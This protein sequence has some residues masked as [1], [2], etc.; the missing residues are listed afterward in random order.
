MAAV[1]TNFCAIPANVPASFSGF[2]RF[3]HEQTE[4]IDLS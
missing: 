3:R 2:W 4:R 1:Y